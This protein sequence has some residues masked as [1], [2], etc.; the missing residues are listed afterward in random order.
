[1]INRKDGWL[2]P[3][4]PTIRAL[5][6]YIPYHGKVGASIEER[7]AYLKSGG[8]RHR[9]VILPAGDED[10]ALPPFD[11]GTATK[12]ELVAFAQTEFVATLSVDTDIRTLRKQVA[13][14]AKNA[15]LT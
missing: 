11:I 1:M 10:D 12:E 14:L 9:A 2:M 6:E 3:N 5:N 7:M 4:V 13:T 15:E 8:Q